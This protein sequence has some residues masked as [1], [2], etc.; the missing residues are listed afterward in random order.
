MECRPEIIVVCRPDSPGM[1]RDDR[2]DREHIEQHRQLELAVVAVCDLRRACRPVRL[3]ERDI[4]HVEVSGPDGAEV[5]YYGGN[6]QLREGWVR[7]R[8]PLAVNDKAGIWTV[9]ARD[10]IS[11]AT[12]ATRL[13]VQP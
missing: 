1:P 11:G 8:L 12:A 3:T 10:P 2:Q 9:Q 13:S 7:Y 6:L 5:P 4:L